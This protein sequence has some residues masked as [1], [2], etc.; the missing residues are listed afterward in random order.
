MRPKRKSP[1][2]PIAVAE[3]FVLERR[4]SG[5][6]AAEF[7]HDASGFFFGD[8]PLIGNQ[9]PNF[10]VV[11]YHFDFGLGRDTERRLNFRSQDQLPV[12]IEDGDLAFHRSMITQL[13]RVRWIWIWIV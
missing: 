5:K 6:H 1:L 7:A 10:A 12:V 8:S 4:L 13:S 2:I 3:L 11:D 9:E